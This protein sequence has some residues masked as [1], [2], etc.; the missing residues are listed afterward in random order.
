MVMRL[1]LTSS[2]GRYGENAIAGVMSVNLT[3]LIIRQRWVAESLRRH[4]CILTSGRSLSTR[5]CVGGST[6]KP[7]ITGLAER[8]EYWCR[9]KAKGKITLI[10]CQARPKNSESQQLAAARKACGF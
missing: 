7:F 4:R 5:C 8:A 1:I 10:V 2:G 6:P 9:Q 3:G